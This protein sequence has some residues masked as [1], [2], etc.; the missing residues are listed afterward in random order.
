M[1]EEPEKLSHLKWAIDKRYQNQR[2]SLQLLTLLTIHERQWKTK[3]FARAAQ[4]L[5]SVAFSLWRAAFLADKTGKR[6][7]VFDEGKEFLEKIIED[8]T[9]SYP[10]DKKSKEWTFN[11]YTRNAREALQVLNRHWP[12]QVPPYGGGPRI[13]TDRWEYCQSLLD[14]GVTNF[15]NLLR[16]IEEDNDQA[17]KAKETRDAARERR[18]KSRAIS[19]QGAK[20]SY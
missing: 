7:R 11:Y 5:I 18:K 12:E 14:T 8:N 10:Q 1:T 19:R 4:D 6:E 3:K 13:P 17:K 2:C 15:G 16:E 9:I 20:S